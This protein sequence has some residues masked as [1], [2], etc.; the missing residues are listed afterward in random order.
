MAKTVARQRRHR[1]V[2]RTAAEADE[3]GHERAR[4][5]SINDLTAAEKKHWT[6][7]SPKHAKPGDVAWTGPCIDG[8]RIVCYYDANMDPSDCRNHSC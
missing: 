5:F 8:I 6:Q 3:R 1:G 4:N 7:L 2:A